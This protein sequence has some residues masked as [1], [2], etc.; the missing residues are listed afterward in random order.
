MHEPPWFMLAL[1]AN[2]RRSATLAAGRGR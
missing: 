1:D 2:Q